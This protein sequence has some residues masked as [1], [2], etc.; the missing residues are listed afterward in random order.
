M[1]NERENILF[2]RSFYEA[3]KAIPEEHSQIELY[4]TVFDYWFYGKEPDMEDL[5]PVTKGMFA[6]MRPA[7]DTNRQ[8]FA[9]GKKGG[10]K[11][12]RK[13]KG[14]SLSFTDEVV[15]M[16]AD[17]EFASVICGEFSFDEEEFK[18]Q[19]RNF[20]RYCTNYRKDK[21]HHDSMDDARSHFRYWLQRTL[22]TAQTAPV[23]DNPDDLPQPDDV[24]YTY[25]G[26][27]G[28]QD[29]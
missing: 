7:I 19:L 23:I 21:P 22:K 29:M 18:N 26:G 15:Q 14:Y 10:R 1:D 6:L 28:G 11:S 17:H 27:F 12:S 2:Y 13:S 3:I 16:K 4:N 24:D 20:L 9:N 25:T 5:S 8:R